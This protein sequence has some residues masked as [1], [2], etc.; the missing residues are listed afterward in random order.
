MAWGPAL[1]KI[2]KPALI[3]TTPE[4]PC[5]SIC[6]DMQKRIRG[7]RLEIMENAGHALIVD[8]PERFNSL[9]EN[10]ISGLGH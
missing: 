2:D 5:G 3:I 6:A 8:E 7:A 4:G 9:L 10:F 1:A